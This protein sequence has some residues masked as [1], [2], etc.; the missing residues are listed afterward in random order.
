MWGAMEVRH[1]N[2]FSKAM[3]PKGLGQMAYNFLE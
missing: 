1:V 2:P 3:I